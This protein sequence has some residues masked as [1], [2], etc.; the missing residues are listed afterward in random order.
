MKKLELQQIIK[1]EI[2]K[3]LKENKGL[4]KVGDKVSDSMNDEYEVIKVEPK[5]I[6]LKPLTFK[7]ANSIYPQDFSSSSF[8]NPMI[9]EFWSYFDKK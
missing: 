4:P 7:G 5:K 1:E 2:Q 6:T 8:G 3:V 9:E